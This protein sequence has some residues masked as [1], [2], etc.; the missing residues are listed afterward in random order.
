MQYKFTKQLNTNDCGIACL[1]MIFKYHN[2]NASYELIKKEMKCDMEGVSAYE[3]IKESKKHL[4]D[5]QAYKGI[6][7]NEVKTPFIAHTV[8]ENNLQHFVVVYKVSNDSILIA[9][10]SFGIKNVPKDNFLKE[11]TGVGITFKRN[12]EFDIK[13]AY[14]NKKMIK[15]TMVTLLWSFLSILYS[16]NISFIINSLSLKFNYSFIYYILLIFL[17]IGILKEL[18]FYLRNKLTLSF[19]LLV[20]KKL[21]VPVFAKT[22]LLPSKFYQAHPSGELISKINDL[23]YVKEMVSKI[24]EIFFV[25]IILIICIIIV[26]LVFEPF[27]IILLAVFSILTF[28]IN[29]SYYKKYSYINYDLQL[30]N[31]GLSDTIISCL[32]NILLI[33]NYVK[34]R[35]FISKIN[36]KY[37]KL[38][39]IYNSLYKHYLKREMIIGILNI[40]FD[41]SI[42]ICSLIMKIN[43]NNLV[44]IVF[45][46]NMFMGSLNEIYSLYGTKPDYDASIKRINELFKY[47]SIRFDET[48]FKIYRIKIKNYSFKYNNKLI[49]KKLNLNIKNSD[50]IMV[51]GPTGSGKSTLFKILTKQISTKKAN[52]YFNDNN[53]NSVLY[54]DIKNNITYVDQKSKLFSDTIKNN[55]CLD[56]N[57]YELAAKTTLIDKML[58]NN[59]IGYD[60]KIDSIN[61]NLSGGDIQKILIA[62]A[63]CNCSNILILD[64]TTS[65][66]D[67]ETEKQILINI[68]KNYKHLGLILISH[69]CTN[70]ELFDKVLKIEKGILK[71]MEVK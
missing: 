69:N 60:Y 65:Q 17:F 39:N 26:F 46:S 55:I 45:L 23:S 37:N 4:L 44:F 20:D 7:I 57:N 48:N 67:K 21:S 56:S 35:F 8:N 15:I 53:I 18:I 1:S 9:D 59:N 13:N 33:K 36:E 52:I 32:N 66:L 51:T 2:I 31:E 34:E 28:I 30:K 42:I 61:D 41:I 10:P 58:K 14:N 6:N 54:K 49:L 71:E 12:E 27:L 11:F 16:Y 63:L 47:E 5:A 29:K 3:I 19:R 64:E 43:I 38:H 24:T 22:L 68:K 62:Q 40:I 50:W 70:K 25:N